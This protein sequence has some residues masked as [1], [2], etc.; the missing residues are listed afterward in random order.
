[1]SK[2]R[3]LVVEDEWPAREYLVELLEESNLAEVVG[4][5]GTVAEARQALQDGAGV[6]VDAAFVDIRLA[7]TG[8]VGGLDLVRTLATGPTAPMFVL[9]TAFKDYAIEAFSLD[10]VD[11]L[12]K[13][14]TAERVEQCLHRLL[15]RRPAAATIAPRRIIARRAKTL[16]FLDPSEVWAFEAR[17]R[18]TSV[19][20][21][22]GVFDMDVSLSAIEISV[23]RAFL[24][25]HRNWLVNPDF[26]KELE[27]DGRETRIFVGVGLGPEQRGVRIPIGRDRVQAVRDVLFAG[28]AGTRGSL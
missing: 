24:R 2:L 19:H 1:V 10:V 6:N 23:G 4:A 7:G 28:A 5:V 13:P 25:V 26:I 8:D 9:A 18:L 12:L 27:R 22:H 17:D 11:Y 3:V 20:T 21:T 15:A 16:V 14:F